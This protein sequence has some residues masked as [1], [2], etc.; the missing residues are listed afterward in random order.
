MENNLNIKLRYI[1]NR[2]PNIT[3]FSSDFNKYIEDNIDYIF[4]VLNND[5]KNIS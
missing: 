5:E 3:P 2:D 1:N 4:I